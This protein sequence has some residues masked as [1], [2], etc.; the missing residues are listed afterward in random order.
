VKRRFV[1]TGASAA[2]L[3]DSQKRIVQ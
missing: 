3:G 2:A 1:K